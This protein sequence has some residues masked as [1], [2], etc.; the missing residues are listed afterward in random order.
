MAGSVSIT[1][2]IPDLIVKMC[3][4]CYLPCAIVTTDEVIQTQII[5]AVST[6][7]CRMIITAV[8]SWYTEW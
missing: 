8:S 6:Q 1:I 7:A 2:G 3:P 5:I 4:G